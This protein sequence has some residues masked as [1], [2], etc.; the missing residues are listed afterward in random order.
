MS[1]WDVGDEA[2][3][4]LM[5]GFYSRLAEGLPKGEALRQTKLDM[6]A[7]E[8]WATPYFWAPFIMTGEDQGTL[9]PDTL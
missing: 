3:S 1:L 9:H 8:Q 2:T 4:V 7:S 6:A 5:K